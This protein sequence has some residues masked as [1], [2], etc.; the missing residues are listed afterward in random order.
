MV[1]GCMSAKSVGWASRIN[2]TMDTSLYLQVLEDEMQQSVDYCFDKND[3]DEWFFQQDNAPCHK[4]Q[5]VLKFLD[6]KKI[7]L[8]DLSATIS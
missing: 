3:K 6:D 1:W 4:S 8:L 5:A 2:G 7:R